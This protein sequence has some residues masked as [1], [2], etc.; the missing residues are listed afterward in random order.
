MKYSDGLVSE[1]NLCDCGAE[2]KDEGKGKEKER[3]GGGGDTERWCPAPVPLLC[4]DELQGVMTHDS[5]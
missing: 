2:T 5:F 1:R 3:K 4:C